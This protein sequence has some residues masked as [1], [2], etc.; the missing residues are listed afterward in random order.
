MPQTVMWET[1]GSIPGLGRFPWRR[2]RLPT[3]VFWPG[4]FHGLCCP[5]GHKELDMTERLSLIKLV[6]AHE[7]LS[8]VS[9]DISCHQGDFPYS[10]KYF[11][12][13][14]TYL[15]PPV[16]YNRTE[17]PYLALVAGHLCTRT[18]LF[19]YYLTSQ[20]LHTGGAVSSFSRH[21]NSAL[22]MFCNVSSVTQQSAKFNICYTA[23]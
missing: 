13:S 23:L 20:Q 16:V 4:E 19:K 12:L 14:V 21:R 10:M 5:Q 2:E 6:K 22:K 9:K 8:P 3:P 17:K 15:A 11:A 7:L 1:V 18:I